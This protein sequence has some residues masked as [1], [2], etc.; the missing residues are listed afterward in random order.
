M[1]VILDRDGVIN[2]YHG[3]YICSFDE[4]QLIPGVIPLTG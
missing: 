1:L 2:R 3:Q 4:W